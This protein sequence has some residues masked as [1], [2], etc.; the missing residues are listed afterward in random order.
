MAVGGDHATRRL[1]GIAE[2]SLI[3]V[4]NEKLSRPL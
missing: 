2:R 3:A 4:M 1:G